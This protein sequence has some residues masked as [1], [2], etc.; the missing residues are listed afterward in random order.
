VSFQQTTGTDQ[1]NLRVV[2]TVP[3]GIDT[4]GTDPTSRVFEL[5]DSISAVPLPWIGSNAT[6]PDQGTVASVQ[7]SQARIGSV[8]DGPA[9][10]SQR[11]DPCLPQSSLTIQVENTTGQTISVPRFQLIDQDGRW[12]EP[13]M[14]E[15]TRLEPR[16]RTELTIP[17][18]AIFGIPDRVVALFV[19]TAANS[20]EPFTW[21]RVRVQQ[22]ATGIE[23]TTTSSTPTTTV[24][25]EAD[26]VSTIIAAMQAYIRQNTQVDVTQI[27]LEVDT[28][29]G[30]FAR[31][32]ISPTDGS[33]DP[34]AGYLK[35]ENARWTVITFGTMLSPEQAQQLGIPE[36][37][38]PPLP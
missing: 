33:A 34:A 27:T 2:V 32:R 3:E 19:S 24:T 38:I 11:P 26:D 13:I 8:V 6:D 23:A 9:L 37:I 4:H 10:V 36:S 20:V 15:L 16:Q 35:R 17:F 28:I 12:Y 29:E 22:T 7:V 31:V 21:V 14:P 25:L 18:R 1:D 30:N 5:S